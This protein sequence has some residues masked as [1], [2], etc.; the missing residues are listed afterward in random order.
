MTALTVVPLG[1]G[2]DDLEAALASAGLP[3]IDL[4]EPGRL[5]F[6]FDDATGPVGFAGIEGVGDDRL[7]RSVVIIGERRGVGLGSAVAVTLEAAAAKIGAVT[8]HLLTT[9]A[10]PFFARHGYKIRER[11]AA[12]DAIRASREFTSL[13][14]DSATYMAKVVS[15]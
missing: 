5:F 8:L 1:A 10:A 2:L 3:V 6:R 11:S 13:C 7:L 4:R 15:G 14:P 9:D 12:P